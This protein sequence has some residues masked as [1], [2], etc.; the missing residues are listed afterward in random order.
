MVGLH[1]ANGNTVFTTNEAD[2]SY[3]NGQEHQSYPR[4]VI[5]LNLQNG[6][7]GAGLSGIQTLFQGTDLFSEAVE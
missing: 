3:R 7:K 6:K 4:N 2:Y 1:H 5:L